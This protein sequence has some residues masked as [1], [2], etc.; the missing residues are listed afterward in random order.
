MFRNG[1]LDLIRFSQQ[2][3]IDV[4]RKM[5]NIRVI[6]SDFVEKHYV[7]VCNI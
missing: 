2:Q 3:K 4:K 1:L 6:L 7:P 5:N